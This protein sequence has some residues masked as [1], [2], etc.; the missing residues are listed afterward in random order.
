MQDGERHGLW[1]DVAEAE[2]KQMST[3]TVL[4]A[5]AAFER[6]LEVRLLRWQQDRGVNRGVHATCL[7]MLPACVPA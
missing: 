1:A 7:F 2:Y 3:H 5:N 4:N 6:A